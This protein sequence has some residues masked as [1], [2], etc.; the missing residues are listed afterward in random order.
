MKYFS[1]QLINWKTAISDFRYISFFLIASAYCLCGLYITP[2]Y[3]GYI[4]EREA[5]ALYDPILNALPAIDVSFFIFNIMNICALFTILWLLTHPRHLAI[6]VMT[7]AIVFT[8]RYIAMFVFT[9]DTPIG[10]IQLRDPLLDAM[11]Y[12]DKVISKDLFFSGHTSYMFLMFL[13][14]QN[15]ILKR[16]NVMGMLLVGFLLLL[17]HNHYVVDVVAA[18]FFTWIAFQSSKWLYKK[19]VL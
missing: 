10:Y 19:Q 1:L 15:P 5:I 18:P 14:V 11:I 12:D 7:W 17:Q 6:A 8:L 2:L 4:Q 9:F 3:F 16:V 13:V